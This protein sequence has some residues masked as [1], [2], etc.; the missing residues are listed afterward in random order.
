MGM[1]GSE[2]ALE[3]LMCRVL[4][5][6][7]QEGIVAKIADDLYCGGDTPEELRYNWEHVLSALFENG[8]RLSAKRTVIAPKTTTILGWI[9]SEG[10][11]RA[12]PHHTTALATC[13]P[14][15]TVKGLRSFIGAVKVLAHVI[16]QCSYDIFNSR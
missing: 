14:P 2:T 15:T 8:L 16:P 7:I 12:S 13:D 11:I 4:G 10:T 6:L 1:P 5:E 3:E 9:W